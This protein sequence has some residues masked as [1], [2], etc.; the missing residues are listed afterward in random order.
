MPCGSIT[1]MPAVTAQRFCTDTLPAATRMEQVRDGYA[2]LDMAVDLT[3]LIPER[4]FRLD[5]SS[6]RLNA[7]ASLGSGMLSPYTARRSRAL[8]ARAGIDAVMVTRFT[9]PYRFTCDAIEQ[10]EVTIGD[11]LMVPMDQAFEFV[12]PTVGGIQ[13]I[14]VQRSALAGLLDGPARR[15]SASPQLNLLFDY[16]ASIQR[17]QVLDAPLADLAATH[18]TDLLT[19]ALGVRGDDADLA[20]QRGERAARLAALRAHVACSYHDPQLSVDHLAQQHHMSV[21]QVQRLF[22]ED[23]TTFTLL[24]QERR[25]EHVR[26]ALKSPSQSHLQVATIAHNAGF[27][28]LTAFNRLFKQRYGVS[29]T[30]IREAAARR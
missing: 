15:L 26:R 11:V 6:I 28:E 13:T 29:P 9:Q 1:D 3:P 19:L 25:L 12:Y 24:L 8:A 16:A 4:A 18:L 10:V 23:G 27:N 21:R 17:Q 5:L 20:R 22:E 7:R 2:R 30:Q 14:W